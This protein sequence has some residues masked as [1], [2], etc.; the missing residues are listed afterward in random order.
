MRPIVDLANYSSVTSRLPA[1]RNVFD[2][3]V[4]DPNYMPVTRDLSRAKRTMIRRW[5]DAPRY[6]HLDSVE[7][8]KTALQLAVELEHATI[9]PYLCALYSLRPGTNVE[10]A[11]LIRSVV[12]E[13]MLH[14][15]LAANILIAIGGSPSIGHPG[16]VPTYPGPLP[17]G[18]RDGLVVRLR[19]CSLEQV[20]DVFV[21]IEQP[22]TSRQPVDGQV[23]PFDPKVRASS[24]I[25]WFYDEIER[26]LERLSHQGTIQFGHAERQVTTWSGTG[27]LYAV[28][29]LEDAL[30]AIREIKD[31]GEGTGALHPGDGDRELAHYYKFCEIVAG[32]RL[33]RRDGGF[34]YEGEPIAF[35]VSG[36]W[37]MMD[38]P[39]IT[40]LAAGSRAAV[41]AGL[42]ATTYQSLL[43]ALHETFNGHPEQLGEAVGL[44]FSLDL[45]ARE[46]MQTPSGAGDG[47]AA[48]P[49][50]QAPFVT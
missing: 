48:G 38:D 33:V 10:V 39:D 50:F 21:Q 18:L 16:F 45:A 9:P 5:L 8:L 13:E 24:T 19:R 2:T 34:A 30:K 49:S 44:M 25:G 43:A 15:A 7:D 23:D 41:L 35:D 28:T 32:R 3:P 14:L 12:M 11:L 6:M 47:T 42:F 46:L 29:A 22:E 31:Q 17:G 37:P 20:R 1:L 4:D 27:R 36:V 40:K 26:A